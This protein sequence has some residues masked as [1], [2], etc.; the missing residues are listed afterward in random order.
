MEGDFEARK[1]RRLRD[2]VGEIKKSKAGVQNAVNE[3]VFS[4]VETDVKRSD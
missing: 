4:F 2:I 3:A 1:R